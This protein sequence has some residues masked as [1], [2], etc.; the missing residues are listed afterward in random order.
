MRLILE[1]LV[2]HIYMRLAIIITIISLFGCS[3]SNEL[4][5]ANHRNK[6]KMKWSVPT[7]SYSADRPPKGFNLTESGIK[8]CGHFGQRTC[9][10][11]TSCSDPQVISNMCCV[12]KM[13]IYSISD[14][15]R[16]QNGY[17]CNGV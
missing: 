13:K 8:G 16:I 6:P 17:S 10:K 7:I 12:S 14:S 3:K 1:P 5:I 2:R 4:D 9:Q 11:L 15:V